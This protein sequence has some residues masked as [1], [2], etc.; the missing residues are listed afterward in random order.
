MRHAAL[1]G[2]LG[3]SNRDRH[4]SAFREAGTRQ[5]GSNPRARCAFLSDALRMP[6]W[7]RAGQPTDRFFL[8]ELM[9]TSAR[10]PSTGRRL[11]SFHR[12]WRQSGWEYSFRP[13]TGITHCLPKIRDEAIRF[14]VE[15]GYRKECPK[16]TWPARF[17][18]AAR[19]L[20]LAERCRRW[21]RGGPSC[22]PAEGHSFHIDAGAHR[23]S[24]VR[25]QRPVV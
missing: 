7:P 8:P 1:A 6:A 12:E 14:T 3:I 9:G 17:G 13:L 18:L 24:R 15:G 16:V 11:T 2:V 25:D 4:P 21:R 10:M 20:P 5:S 19:D 23:G 22:V